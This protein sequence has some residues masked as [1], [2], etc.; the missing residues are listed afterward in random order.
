MAGD[1]ALFTFQLVA[2]LLMAYVMHHMYQQLRREQRRIDAD[3]HAGHIRAGTGDLVAELRRTA[4]QINSDMTGRA[5]TLERLIDDANEALRRLDAAA[6]RASAVETT[7]RKPT[8]PASANAG[9]PV[10]EAPRTNESAPRRAERTTVRP[11]PSAPRVSSTPSAVDDRWPGAPV[12]GPT[13]QRPPVTAASPAATS[14]YRQSIEDFVGVD[15]AE[16]GKSQTVRRLAQQGLSAAEIARTA[17]IG[18]EEVELIMRVNGEV[19]S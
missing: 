14:A 19:R 15:L 13:V 12:G 9:R 6:A 5:A 17:Q 3:A 18:R 16:T 8:R 11:E 10:I 2:F 1:Y 7:R 4:E